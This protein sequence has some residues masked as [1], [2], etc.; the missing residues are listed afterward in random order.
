MKIQNPISVPINRTEWTATADSFQ[1]GNEPERSLDANSS[2]FWHSQ[3]SPTPV[4]RL[5][6]WLLVDMK[7]LY[8]IHAVSVQPRPNDNANGRIGGH[9]IHISSDNNTWQLVA[10]GMWNNDATAKKST[11]VSRQARYV[12]VTATSEAQSSSNQWSSIAEINVFH[13][14]VGSTPVPYA[15]PEPGKGLWEKTVDFPLIPVAVSLLA[16]GKLLIWSAFAKDNFGG[17]RGFTQTAIYSPE[18]G[19]SSEL[20]VSNTQHDMFCPGISLDFNGRVIVSGGS[21]AAKVSIYDPRNNAWTS[22]SNMKIAR[23]Y[24]STATCS[25]GR[26][27]AIGGSWSGGEGGKNGEIYDPSTNIWSLLPN[28][29]VDPM[30]TEDSGG[31]WRSDNH[32]FLF[33]WKNGT[34]FQAGPSISINWYGTLGSGSTTGAGKRLD[35]GHAMNGNAMM[36]D[37]TAG[38]ILTT[39]GA[40]NYEDSDA[41]KNAYVITI[42]TPG[43]TPTITRTQNMEYARG[44]ANGV[45]LPDGTVF[46]TGGQSR[47]KPFRDDT[48]ALIPELWDPVRGIWTPLN[49]MAVPRTYHSVAILLPDATVFQGGGGLCGPCT[50]Y[51]G[52]PESNHFDAEI[53]IPPYLLNTD[54]TRRARPVIGTMPSSV[55]IGSSLR[56][57]LDTAMAK[58]SLVRF[59]TATHTVN[60]DQRR[61][62]LSSIANG[63]TYTINIPADPGVALPGYWML[64]AMD[65]NGTPSVGKIIQL[66]I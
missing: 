7:S 65:S 6:N 20:N 35:D 10:M 50:Q 8:N 39:G 54:G 3:Y 44:F 2:T 53:F 40:S 48:A 60:T 36:Y 55:K 56:V 27:F 28:S 21:N 41:R 23:G 26:I 61:I 1:V 25:D 43:A 29:L 30:L 46:V 22:A 18:T 32:A 63:I 64:F 14:V 16:N 47:V 37:A 38:K 58:F 13:E 62:P 31:V 17:Q 4:D 66:T 52:V 19:D 49:P 12:R 42:D 11:F 24:H 9:Q 33:G 57:T 51:G 34:V 15:P 45:V 59:G 5:P